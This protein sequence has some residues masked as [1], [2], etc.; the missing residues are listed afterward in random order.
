MLLVE[1]LLDRRELRRRAETLD[2]EDLVAV[3]LDAED[4]AALHGQP[5]HQHGAGPAARG[6]AAEVGPGQAEHLPDEVEQQQA[7]LDLRLSWLIVNDAL[8]C[9]ELWH[10]LPPCRDV[11][12]CTL[13]SPVELR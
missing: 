2:G 6:V 3:G 10:V 1:T 5:V 4:G 13:R 8:N 7:G 12:P 9:S 11:V